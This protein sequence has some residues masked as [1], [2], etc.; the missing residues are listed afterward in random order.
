[1][2]HQEGSELDRDLVMGVPDD[3][4]METQIKDALAWDGRLDA[5]TIRA[6]VCAGAVILSGYVR[7]EEEKALAEEIASGVRGVTDVANDLKVTG[8]EVC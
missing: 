6:G 2:A 4:G 1:M 3:Q 7:T 8:G 5:S